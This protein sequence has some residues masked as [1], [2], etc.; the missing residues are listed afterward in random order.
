MSRHSSEDQR[1]LL[2][3]HAEALDTFGRHVRAVTPGQWDDPTPCTDWTVR[4]L[5]NHLA[6]E[7]LW[8]PEMLAGRTVA[9]V[10]DRFDGDVLG[11]DP[12]ALWTA[13][14]EAARAG[15]A[16]P[17]ALERTVRLSYGP[18]SAAGYC[19]EM[20]VDAIIHA[21]D[22][23]Q[24]IGADARMPE[25]AARWALAEVTPYADALP[26]SGLFAPAV[27]VAEDADP[28]TRLLGL[29]GRDASAPFG[30]G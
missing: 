1:E 15:F 10:G 27:P 18:R 30:R 17:E 21:W 7:Q 26:S 11:E 5:V 19:R 29:V 3:L 24:G 14:A 12:V 8:V 28:Q 23:A 9:E 20:T 22:L 16:E 6:A 25:A 4:D 2:R 13:A